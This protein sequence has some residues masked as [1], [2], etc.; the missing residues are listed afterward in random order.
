MTEEKNSQLLKSSCSSTVEK[1]P[2]R[3][4]REDEIPLVDGLDDALV[5]H[6]AGAEPQAVYDYDRY[7]NVL[8][9]DGRTYRE[10]VAE[11]EDAAS[12]VFVVK[13]VDPADSRNLLRKLSFRC[14]SFLSYVQEKLVDE[15]QATGIRYRSELASMCAGLREC[16]EFFE[17]TGAEL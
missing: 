1:L 14:S 12:R 8:V 11:V 2:S 6:S 5:G 17:E 7:V 4:G 10:A 13:R 9:E 16:R 3:P 15:E